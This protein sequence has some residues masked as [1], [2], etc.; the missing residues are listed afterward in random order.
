MGLHVGFDDVERH[1][2]ED[3]GNTCC[4]SDGEIPGLQKARRKHK[5]AVV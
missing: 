2:D 3:S 1:G 4:C 5:Q